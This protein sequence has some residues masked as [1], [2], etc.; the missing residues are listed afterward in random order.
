VISLLRPKDSIS[1]V[2]YNNLVDVLAEAS[3]VTPSVCSELVRAVN[4]MRC[5]GS[6][7]LSGGWLQGCECVARRQSAE[8]VNRAL[9]HRRPRQ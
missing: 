9:S 3:S 4:Q 7:N 8:K 6:T 2:A 1:L 5:G